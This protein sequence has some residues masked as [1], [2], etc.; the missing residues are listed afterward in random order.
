MGIRKG[1]S[2]S[3]GGFWLFDLEEKK[4]LSALAFFLLFIIKM[5]LCLAQDHQAW[6]LQQQEQIQAL[7]RQHEEEA[8]NLKNQVPS[9][10]KGKGCSIRNTINCPKRQGPKQQAETRQASSKSKLYIF[11][12]FSMP[13][14]TLKTLA[15]EAKKHNAVLVIRGLI[16]NSFLKT[17]TF[18]KELGEGVILDPLL[19]REYNIVV[20][21]TFIEALQ[22]GYRRVSGNITLAYALS[23]FKED[24][25]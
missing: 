21:P 9:T 3:R 18:L 4:L 22:A 16:G 17:A 13:K 15:V 7:I 20:V 23:R 6:A 10:F 11:V 12:S 2:L 5:P 25:E 19:F 14:E 24:G 1:I 8:L